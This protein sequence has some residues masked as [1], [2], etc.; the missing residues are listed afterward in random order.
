MAKTHSPRHGSM[1]YWPRVRAKSTVARVR[2]WSMNTKD[3]VLGFI[4][5]KAGM[6]HIMGIDTRKTSQSKGEEIVIPTTVIE[7]PPMKIAGFRVYKKQYLYDQPFKDFLFKLDKSLSRK[8]IVP[9]KVHSV[10]YSQ[11]NPDELTDLRILVYTQPS[12]TGIQKKKPEL[13]EIGLSGSINDKI[14][15]VKENH[16]K[17]LLASSLFKEGEF[18]DIHAITKGKGFQG[19]VKRFGVAFKPHKTEKGVRRVGTLGAWSGQGHTLYRVPHAGQMGYHMRTEHN[20][21]II[22]ISNKPEEVNPKGA[23]PR[24][25]NVKSNFILVKGSISGAR[26]RAIIFTKSLRSRAAESLPTITYISKE[27][28][29]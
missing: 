28:K 6:T 22:K 24:Y 29:Q 1:Q 5:Y 11:L 10:D 19:P 25:G 7:C 18:V 23:F 20:K 15:F 4:G 16:D 12:M 27:S 13:M 21:Q 3:H 2:S 14:N 8:M 9:K 17:E 26:K